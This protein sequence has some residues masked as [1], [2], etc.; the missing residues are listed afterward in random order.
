MLPW[1][2]FNS[3]YLYDLAETIAYTKPNE[4]SAYQKCFLSSKPHSLDE[5]SAEHLECKMGFRQGSCR[6]YLFQKFAF[7]TH[8]SGISFMRGRHLIDPSLSVPSILLI[9]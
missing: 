7:L 8:A 1:F 2:S 3:L 6:C 4:A 5:F 9:L